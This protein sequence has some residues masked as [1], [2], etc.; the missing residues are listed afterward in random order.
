MGPF[1]RAAREEET[2]ASA[3]Q[4][5][6]AYAI[7]REVFAVR[8]LWREIESLDNKVEAKVQYDAIF[9]ISRMVRRAV[10]WLLQNYPQQLEIEPMVSRFRDGVVEAFAT[11][12]SII[13]SRGAERYAAETQRLEDAGLPPPVAQRIAALTLAAQSFDIVELAREFGCPSRRSAGCTSR[14]RRSCG[15]DVV[16]EQIEALKVDSRWR[17]MARATLRETLAQEQ[18]SLLRTALSASGA[19]VASEGRAHAWLAKH[20]DEIA[21]ARRGLD[22]M[23]DDG[24]VGLRDAVG[25]A[26]GGRPAPLAHLPRSQPKSPVDLRRRTPEQWRA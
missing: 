16:R 22:D 11:L 25:R 12:P 21:R 10:Y 20:H 17:A 1:V 6:R 2:G 3:A 15:L 7:A 8:S 18:R 9:Q 24:A 14:S 13:A 5:A 26:Q 4:V 19:S 23:R